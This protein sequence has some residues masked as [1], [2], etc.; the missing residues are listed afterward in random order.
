MAT[1]F[2][3][4]KNNARSLLDSEISAAAL[5]LTLT[6]GGGSLF[7]TT[8]P[9]HITIDDEIC[10]V[11]NNASDVLTITRAKQSTSA[12]IHVAGVRVALFWTAKSISD[13]NTAVN[14]LEAY[15]PVT[16][17]TTRGDILYRNATVPARL[18]KGAANTVLVMGAN[19]PAW[20][21]TLVGLTLTSPTINGTIAT[22]GL[23]LPTH[24]SGAIVISGAELFGLSRSVDNGY[25][26][27][28]GGTDIHGA[29]IVLCGK[30]FAGTPGALEIYT[31]NAALGAVGRL[32][33]SGGV[34]TAVATW[35]NVTHTGIVTSDIDINGGTIDG[36]TIT[37]PTIN[38][39]IATTGLTLPAV[40]LSGSVTGAAQTMTGMGSING[41]II[42]ANT[43]TIT[44]G[45]WNG[46]TIAV[47]NGGTGVTTSTGTVAVVLSTSPTLVTPI[48][49]VATATSINKITLT[50]PA[51]GATLTLVEGSSLITAGAYAITLTATGVTGV[52]L[53]TT[54]TLST[55]AGSE[56]FT[57][58]TL[59]SPTI[60]GTVATT[61]LTLPA[62]TLGGVTT[63][64]ANMYIVTQSGILAC[65]A[66]TDNVTFFYGGTNVAGY[67]ARI[68]A[69]GKTWGAGNGAIW[70]DTPN[71]AGDADITR[72][73]ISGV[74]ATAV[75]TW[76][77]I[78]QTWS[79]YGA[80]TLT[81]DASGNITAVSDERF[82]DI[83]GA[84]TAGL[85]EI[86]Q[87]NPVMYKYNTLSGMDKEH[88]YAG[89][90]AQNVMQFIPSAVGV[91][92]R[93]YY[94]LND[95]PI[96]ASLV[97]AIKDLQAQIDAL[98]GGN[99]PSYDK[100]IA[101]VTEGLNLI[102]SKVEKLLMNETQ[103]EVKW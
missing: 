95:R 4:V 45:I 17:L 28:C 48:L 64:A 44:T 79:S 86:L 13:L 42:T 8:Y 12:A 41:L 2:L 3:T 26:R 20:S 53:P 62:V 21:A 31:P 61:G 38:G 33:I 76:A 66:A 75:A 73:T 32:N 51:T 67:G 46:T 14:A 7:P 27:L 102:R 83:Q 97:N 103:K 77:N 94:T 92:P 43:G 34:N 85:R 60:N 49:G 99:K 22:T 84:F 24:T 59:T 30:T 16:V 78:T 40:T 9:F 5:S 19:D 36:V 29:M 52:T 96:I 56:I 101:P 91:D 89:F 37:S 100:T 81:T 23:T 25:M 58:K 93:G 82:K 55:L 63:L 47:A 11:S 80:G 68:L 74:A 6:A 72:L 65:Q 71:A 90:S 35:S 57:N 70:L 87:L 98:V 88:L 18:A 50:Q 69:G 10:E 39:T 1:S 15:S 54:G